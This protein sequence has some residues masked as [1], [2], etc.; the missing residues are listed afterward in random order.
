MLSCS[1][2]SQW[3]LQLSHLQTWMQLWK[4]YCGVSRLG[5]GGRMTSLEAFSIQSYDFMWLRP[6]EQNGPHA[7]EAGHPLATLPFCPPNWCNMAA[8]QDC[9]QSAPWKVAPPAV[10]LAAQTPV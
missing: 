6:R 3:K 10:Y 4:L 5:G 9:A 8:C 7:L 2:W 1:L